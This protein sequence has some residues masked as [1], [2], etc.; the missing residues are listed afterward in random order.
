M[1]A[2]SN[3]TLVTVVAQA[4]VLYGMA[5]QDV[6]PSV[7]AKIHPTRRSPY[8]ALLFGAAVVSALLLI[9][10]GIRASQA[11]L[12]EDDQLDIVDRLA[13]ITVVFLLFIYALVIVACLKLRGR[14]ESERTYR[15]NTPLLILGILGN[16]TVLVYTLIDDPGA[17]LW[18]AG[19]L[20]VGTLLYLAEKFFGHKQD[21]PA[22][23]SAGDPHVVEPPPSANKEL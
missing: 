2:I 19:L 20:A 8:V 23:T 11:G 14:D 6:V 15:A 1:I 13:T 3:T 7:F 12:P 16:L 21:R 9:G 22:G 5:R 17:L 4:R 18:V 10:A